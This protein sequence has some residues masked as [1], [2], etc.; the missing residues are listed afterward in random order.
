MRQLPGLASQD[1]M[2][3]GYGY[4]GEGDWKVSAMTSL[5]KRMTEGMEGGTTFMEDY[6]Y[7]MEKGN[8]LS[9]GAHMLEICPTITKER[10]RI[11]VHELGIGGKEPPAR[12]VF[13][14]HP[15]RA[16]LASLI[17]MG[18]TPAT[19]SERDRGGEANLQ[20]AEP[21][22]CQGHVETRTR[23][24]PGST[25]LDACRRCPPCSAEL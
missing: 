20:N 13:E 12:L 8:E 2:A 18:G 3:E 5:V 17:D 16:I 6:T 14:G 11:E 23:S 24:I 10:A 4:G 9:L 19:D 25:S 21:S 7:H 22:S 15:G 1:L